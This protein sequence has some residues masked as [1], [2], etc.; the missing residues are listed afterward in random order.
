[1][2]MASQA[3][4][5]PALSSLAQAGALAGVLLAAGCAHQ[6]PA[7]TSDAEWQQ[8]LAQW[9]DVQVIALGEQHEQIA[10]HQWEAQTVKLLAAQQRLSALVIEMAPAGGSTAGLA[11]TATDEEAQQALLWQSGGAGGGWPWKDYGPMVMNAVRAG[12][13]VLGGNLPR[14]QMKQ[15]MGEARYDSHLPA[16]GWQLQLDAIK[17]GHCGLLPESQFAPMARIQL[18]RDESMAKV[19]AAAVQ[20]Q[21]QPGQAVML[22]AGRGHV[23]SDI[24]VPTWL[25]AN[26]KQKVAIA[27][28]DKAQSAINMK[29]DKLLTL[30]G[31]PSEDQ[32]AKL[33]KQWSNRAAAKP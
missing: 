27:Q 26:L 2:W 5:R 17:E 14:A 31:S 22:V 8:T 33:R 20:Q 32:C 13:P 28:S 21:S 7:L 4:T 19:T 10:H 29:A 15:I 16:A 12:V 18:A 30:P 23:R 6:S 24:G 11:K 1:M 9:S 3:L 25:P